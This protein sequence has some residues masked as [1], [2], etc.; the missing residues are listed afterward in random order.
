VSLSYRFLTRRVMAIRGG[1]GIRGFYSSGALTVSSGALT[2]EES[3][4]SKMVLG[5]GVVDQIGASW[6]RIAVWLRQLEAA[7]S[8]S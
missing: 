5:E 7:R 1:Y 6:N 2:V 3:E 8:A 4:C